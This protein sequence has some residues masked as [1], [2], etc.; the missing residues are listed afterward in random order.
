MYREIYVLINIQQKWASHK[1]RPVKMAKQ[2]K[3]A[4]T[5]IH[6]ASKTFANEKFAEVVCGFL[7]FPFFV[8]V[9]ASVCLYLF[10]CE[11]LTKWWA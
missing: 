7:L 4:V 5:D 8:C 9:H 6:L 1:L 11:L 10:L 3:R 2:Y